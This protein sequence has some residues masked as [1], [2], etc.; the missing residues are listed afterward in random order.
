MH[1]GKGG[2]DN[3]L[4]FELGDNGESWSISLGT[5]ASLVEF[6]HMFPSDVLALVL[7]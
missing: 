2:Q 3:M 5:T 4:I 6:N 1:L 7:Q